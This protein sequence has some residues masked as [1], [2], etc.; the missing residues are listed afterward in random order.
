MCHVG[1]YLLVAVVYQILSRPDSNLILLKWF[2][3]AVMFVSVPKGKLSLENSRWYGSSYIHKLQSTK[4]LLSN[5]KSLQRIVLTFLAVE[6]HI[7]VIHLV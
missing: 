5:F 6:K 4:C 2:L 1:Y 7:L 3:N